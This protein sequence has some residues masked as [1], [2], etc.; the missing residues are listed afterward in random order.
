MRFSGI[1]GVLSPEGDGFG[2]VVAENIPEELV[3]PQCGTEATDGGE[4]LIRF[5]YLINSIVARQLVNQSGAV[6]TVVADCRS[7]GYYGPGPTPKSL[8]KKSTASDCCHECFEAKPCSC[9]ASI[10]PSSECP[11]QVLEPLE[12]FVDYVKENGITIWRGWWASDVDLPALN[13]LNEVV[14]IIRGR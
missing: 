4:C 13:D 5:E 14:K 8:Y 6:L 10:T 7:C 9:E 11:V 3:C 1:A 12:R 2:E